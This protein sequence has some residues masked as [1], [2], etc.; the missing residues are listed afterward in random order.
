MKC[1][2][3]EIAILNIQRYILVS[4]NKSTA[5]SKLFRALFERLAMFSA[6]YCPHMFGDNAP[7][8]ENSEKSNYAEI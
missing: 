8:S 3:S 2:K 6:S 1:D 5:S 7:V 4:Q